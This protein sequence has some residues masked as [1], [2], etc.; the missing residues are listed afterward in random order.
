MGANT[1]NFSFL[2]ANS[3]QLAKLGR[4]AERYFADDPPTA[5]VKLRQFAEITA[6]EV[7]ARQALLPDGRAS[8]DDIL[9]I[10]RA[11]SI[12]QREIADLFYHLKRTG[13][14]AAHEDKGTANDALTAL[15]IA[16]AIGGWFHQTYGN[17]PSF[18]LGPF[19]PPT[20]PED[21]SVTLRQ[22]IA[23]LRQTVAASADAEAKGQ[24]AIQEAESTR[25]TLEG[26][27]EAEARERAF[28][29]SYAADTEAAL[30]AAERS[31]ADMQARRSAIHETSPCLPTRHRPEVRGLMA[32]T[33]SVCHLSLLRT[34]VLM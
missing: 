7:A 13:N 21:A 28:W 2:E 29:E 30:R 20:A 4:L 23:T 15:K 34:A 31:L 1:G 8:F 32:A 10:L 22:E 11:R 3:P 18:R 9:R 12:F 33:H 6:K 25:R 24:L 26:R 19:I 17:A 5:L 14:D 27:A 16:R